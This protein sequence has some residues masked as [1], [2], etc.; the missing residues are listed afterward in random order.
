MLRQR[1]ARE[2]NPIWL[3]AAV[4]LAGSAV[5]G[6][7]W[8]VALVPVQLLLAVA[9]TLLVAVVVLVS[10]RG[11][12]NSASLMLALVGFVGAASVYRDVPL[13]PF[14]GLAVLSIGMAGAAGVTLLL[15]G[16]GRARY[17]GTLWPLYAFMAWAAVTSLINRPT[18][19]GL[20][21][22]IV[23]LAF[24]SVIVVSA[25]AEAGNAGIGH[26]LGTAISWAMWAAA[27]VFVAEEL[28]HASGQW[29][30]IGARGFALLA[31]VGLSWHLARWR[32]GQRVAWLPAVLLIG[33]IAVSLSRTALATA[34]VL[35]GLCQVR[36][37]GLLRWGRPL[38][39]WGLAVILL[40]GAIE[41]VQPLRARFFQGDV[42]FSVGGVTI[43]GMGRTRLWSA[44]L[45]SY[46][47]SPW[48]G[49]GAG[50]AGALIYALYPPLEHPHNDYL[51]LLHDYGPLGLLLWMLGI[52]NLAR[53]AY[54]RWRQAAS[55]DPRTA[56]L[57]LAALLA[58]AAISATM[59]TDN[60]IT[61]LF[62]M[63]PAAALTGVSLS[64]AR[65]PADSRHTE[66][67]PELQPETE[68]VPR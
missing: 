34:L 44:T 55:V 49:K 13:G 25:N 50:S 17:V 11:H 51:R 5:T 3:V 6:A 32:S 21:N 43:N 27:V 36:P 68:A 8:S 57:H 65:R 54:C 29:A 41:F 59:I 7:L 46:R 31:L 19:D 30:G 64:A 62:V 56:Q 33:L 4:A 22:L 14:S 2:L 39:L 16:I 23:M 12:L 18:V 63:V 67:T 58:L 35:V 28:T 40:L 52:W 37:R 66:Y 48:I 45:R 20:Q 61:Y 42:T 60:V 38:V 24:L 10:Q 9:V 26:A 1:A 15:G 47:Q 53:G